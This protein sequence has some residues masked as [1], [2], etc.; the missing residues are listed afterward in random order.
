MVAVTR[1]FVGF[2]LFFYES[3][4]FIFEH[5]SLKLFLETSAKSLFYKFF[6]QVL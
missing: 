1:D 3:E 4:D 2:L 6:R 5:L